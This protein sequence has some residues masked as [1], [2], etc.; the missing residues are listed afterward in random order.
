MKV[1]IHLSPL[2]MEMRAVLALSV[3]IGHDAPFVVEEAL[4]MYES[5]RMARHELESRFARFSRQYRAMHTFRDYLRRVLRSIRDGITTL[6]AS[7]LHR[8]S[9]RVVL[10]NLTAILDLIPP[11]DSTL[12]A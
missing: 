6:A 11:D 3:A 2:A 5:E 8:D 9:D 12:W 10:V 7:L 1:D 4:R